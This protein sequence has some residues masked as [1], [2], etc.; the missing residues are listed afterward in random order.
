MLAREPEDRERPACHR[1]RLEYEQD[2][3]TCGDP[4]QRREQ[5]QERVDVE[6]ESIVL[7]PAER[8]RLE[9]VSVQGVPDRLHH[10]PEVEP[11][12]L[13]DAVVQDGAEREQHRVRRDAG[14]DHTHC[15]SGLTGIEPHASSHR[16]DRALET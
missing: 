8:R 2:R 3:P 10:V 12:H 1:D 15:D 6:A 11:R 9:E 16:R 5:D 13:E 7:M 14:I 4:D